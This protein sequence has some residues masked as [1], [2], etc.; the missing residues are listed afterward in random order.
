MAP[1][2]AYRL[3]VL[4]MFAAISPLGVAP[5]QTAPGS[6]IVGDVP[7]AGGT[8]GVL[9]LGAK[10]ARAILI[11]LPGGNGIIG[12][13]N[14]GG[15]HQLGSN[16]LVRT[17][18]Q[19]ATQGFAVVLPDAP[20]GTSLTGQRHLP[21]YADAISKAIDFGRSRAALPVW[22]IGT[23]AGTTAAVN[24]AAH[25]GSKVSG[26]VLTSPVTRSGRAGETIFD[27]EPGAI[28]VPVLVV[29]NEY[30]T[31]AET[32]PGDAPM[33]VSALTRSPRRE[34]VM[35]TSSQIVR[36]SDPCEGMSPH[37]YLGIESMVVSRISEWIIPRAGADHGIW[38]SQSPLAVR[39]TRAI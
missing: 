10:E 15:I 38:N 35:V 29:S 26:A 22:L 1:T 2:W 37:G 21:A 20:N 23:S 5:G 30:D 4:L 36:R 34:L 3:A 14:G 27:A 32:P 39:V 6:P 7:V 25:I 12:L 11:L 28:V 33:V 24:G 9:F 18:G 8:E 13:D 19:W 31:C 16:F 17:F